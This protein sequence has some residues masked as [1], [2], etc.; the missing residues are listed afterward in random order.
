MR[1]IPLHPR[2]KTELAALAPYEPHLPILRRSKHGTLLAMG[3]GGIGHIFERWLVKQG[4]D[5]T[6]HGESAYN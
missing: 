1:A 2:L 6:A 4:L 5:I 3:Y